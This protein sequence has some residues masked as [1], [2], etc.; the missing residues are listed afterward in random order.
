M[1]SNHHGLHALDESV[2]GR[3][4]VGSAHRC[5]VDGADA[6]HLASFSFHAGVDGG[7]F[8][9]EVLRGYAGP[10]APDHVGVARVAAFS[11]SV[12]TVAALG[13]E[14]H[15]SVQCVRREW[16]RCLWVSASETV[17]ANPAIKTKNENISH[18]GSPRRSSLFDVR[19]Y[20]S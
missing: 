13:A 10:S 19:R 3:E 11:S 20:P 5:V 7:A 12:D 18:V 9:F 8:V 1:S 16:S 14:R 4:G 2:V 6:T 15:L 17:A